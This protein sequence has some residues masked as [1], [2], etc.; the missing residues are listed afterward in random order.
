LPLWAWQ[1]WAW[2]TAPCWSSATKNRLEM[3]SR[4]CGVR[5]HPGGDVLVAPDG[6]SGALQYQIAGGTR[7]VSEFLELGGLS[8]LVGVSDGAQHKLN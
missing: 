8:T 5:T 3:P 7:L 2:H 1:L 6:D 4:S